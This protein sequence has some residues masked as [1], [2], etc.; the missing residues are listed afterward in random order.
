VAGLARAGAWLDPTI[1]RFRIQAS[2]RHYQVIHAGFAELVPLLRRYRIPLLAGT[3]LGDDR[4]APGESLHDELAL[5]VDAG[6]TPAEA[7]RAAVTN[8]VRLLGLADS[9]GSIAPGKAAELVL[10]EANPLVD[11]RSTRRIRL[12]LHRGRLLQ[13]GGI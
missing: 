4:I 10:L 9:L 1:S 13:P 6:V 12:V 2:L 7:L 5:L 11:I 3:D 8:P